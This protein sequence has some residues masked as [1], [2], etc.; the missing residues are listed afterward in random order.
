MSSVL[1]LGDILVDRNYIGKSTNLTPEAPVPTV[2]VE[3]ITS[4]LGG[5]IGNVA[6][7]L[8]DFFQK[9][10]FISSF[11]EADAKM[12]QELFGEK[13]CYTNF[14]QE[15]RRM[16]V[17]NRVMVGNQLMSRFDYPC[18]RKELSEEYEN[19]IV[20]HIRVNLLDE[21]QVSVESLIAYVPFDLTK[22]MPFIALLDKEGMVLYYKNE[23]EEISQIRRGCAENLKIV[24]VN[25]CGDAL[26][27]ATAVFLQQHGSLKN[28]KQDLV[29]ILTQIGKI[30]VGTSGCYILNSVDFERL[31]KPRRVIFTNGCFDMIHVGHLKL[32]NYCRGLGD[33]LVIGINSDNSIKLN[34]GGSRPINNLDSRINFLK[35]LNIA[36][37]IIPF[38]IKLQLN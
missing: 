8:T 37:E 12:V 7:S 14:E 21:L 27:T 32:L 6:R 28:H 11:H 9:V 18:D 23:A 15:D 5:G 38:E 25:G 29:N 17:I 16:V 30:A 34:K 19:E 3:T 10:H 1:L 24:D 4:T 22:L 26:I 35:E 13:V 33:H 20:N 36:D 2:K 31:L